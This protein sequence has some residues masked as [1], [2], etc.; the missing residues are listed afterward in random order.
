MVDVSIWADEIM[1]SVPG[2]TV[3]VV[4]Q[5]LRAAFREFCV[6]SGAWMRELPAISIVEGQET[7]T[8]NPQD[9]AQ[10]LYI[11]MIVFKPPP[12][13]S[14]S[15]VL[16]PY[17]QPDKYRHTASTTS[18][19]FGYFG[20]P[21]FPGN[22]SLRP[23]PDKDI[24]DSLFVFATLGPSSRTTDEFPDFV[25]THYFDVILD[26]AM[27]R[28]TA[29]SDRPYTNIANAQYHLRRFRA[30]MSQARDV[31]RRQFTTAES[32]FVYPPWASVPQ[33]IRRV[34]R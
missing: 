31:T 22:F 6:Q 14:F 32:D 20:D 17:Q 24:P 1:P 23:I 26:G 11:Q 15:R 2:A 12:P 33:S 8:V 3:A 10:V 13:G 21:E 30:G 27:G 7:Y 4:K 29:Q 19:P 34:N 28:L 5:A 16:T 18:S 25:G 9:D